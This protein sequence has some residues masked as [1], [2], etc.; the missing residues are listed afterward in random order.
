LWGA[1]K[2]KWGEKIGGKG[3]R[4]LKR[5]RVVDVLLELGEG[6]DEAC[7]RKEEGETVLIWWGGKGV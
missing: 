1:T 4:F 6:I 7:L 2:K 5:K 3:G